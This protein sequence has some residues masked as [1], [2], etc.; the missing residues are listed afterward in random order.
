MDEQVSQSFI[1]ESQSTPHLFQ[2]RKW[3]IISLLIFSLLAVG[4]WTWLEKYFEE[5]SK[6]KITREDPGNIRDNLVSPHNRKGYQGKYVSFSY[7]SEYVRRTEN[8]DVKFPLQ[9]RLLFTRTDVEGRKISVVVSDLDHNPLEEYGAYRIRKDNPKEYQ[10]EE[11]RKNDQKGIMFT[12]ERSIFEVGI[13]LQHKNQGASII[14]SSPTTQEGL[15]EEA[16]LLWESF[17]WR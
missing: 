5:K 3:F 10:V 12:R 14:V 7:P 13:F 11:V 15:R 2:R 8:E 16:E 4:V 1:S 17:S 6:G 9:E